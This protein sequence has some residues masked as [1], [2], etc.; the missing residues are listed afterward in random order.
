MNP[1]IMRMV[2]MEMERKQRERE[3]GNYQHIA[4]W[5]PVHGDLV[6]TRSHGYRS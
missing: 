6:K 2:Q 4:D 3:H 1:C 5:P